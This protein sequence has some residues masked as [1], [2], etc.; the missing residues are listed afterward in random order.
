MKLQQFAHA[1][2]L[3]SL[4]YDWRKDAAIH[5]IINSHGNGT[6]LA[7]QTA[8]EADDGVVG[9]GI[10]ETPQG[11]IGGKIRKLACSCSHGCVARAGSSCCDLHFGV[12]HS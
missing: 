12:L 3:S 7:F 5:V 10:R 8:T 11:F 6:T 1:S 9:L 2:E 4:Q